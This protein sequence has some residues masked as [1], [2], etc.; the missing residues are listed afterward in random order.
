MYCRKYKLRPAVAK[1]IKQTLETNFGVS[2][3][4]L[5]VQDAQIWHW[6]GIKVKEAAIKK[7]ITPEEENDSGKSSQHKIFGGNIISTQRTKKPPGFIQ[8]ID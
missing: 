5:R 3:A 1:Y 2:D 8:V 4:Y 6:V 7:Y